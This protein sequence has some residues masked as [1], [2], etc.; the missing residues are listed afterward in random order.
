MCLWKTAAEVPLAAL[1]LARSSLLHYTLRG[2]KGFSVQAH[3]GA[4]R[5]AWLFSQEKLR[6]AEPGW[7]TLTLKMFY[8]PRLRHPP[9]TDS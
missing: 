9:D 2:L 7:Y 1:R 3:T 6:S 4:L 8:I 5:A